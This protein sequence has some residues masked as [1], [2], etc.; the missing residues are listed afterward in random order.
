MLPGSQRAAHEPTDTAPS[1]SQHLPIAAKRNQYFNTHRKCWVLTLSGNVCL[2]LQFCFPRKKKEEGEAAFPRF[3]AAV[4]GYIV[5]RP[6]AV[7]LHVLNRDCCSRINFNSAASK[8]YQSVRTLVSG[9][10]GTAQIESIN[11]SI[12]RFSIPPLAVD[13]KWESWDPGP[14]SKGPSVIKHAAERWGKEIPWRR[15]GAQRWLHKT[16][17]LCEA[18]STPIKGI[19]APNPASRTLARCANASR[20]R[21]A[22]TRELQQQANNLFG[23]R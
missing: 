21:D 10:R 18:G 7:V 3:A 17:C 16:P 8:A 11:A 5:F 9:E 15:R 22:Q 12:N 20:L 13:L 6:H 19:S 1:S 4:N 14:H 2:S 23:L